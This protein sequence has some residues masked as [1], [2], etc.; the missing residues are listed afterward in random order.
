MGCWARPY[1]RPTYTKEKKKWLIRSIFSPRT[2]LSSG[3]H[4]QSECRG[5]IQCIDVN[6]VTLLQ[7][8]FLLK[9]L[10]IKMVPYGPSIK[11][12][13][14][15]FRWTK[16]VADTNYNRRGLCLLARLPGCQAARRQRPR[17]DGNDFEST[18]FSTYDLLTIIFI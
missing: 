6:L 1:V 8:L 18:I 3:T 13:F 2:L 12:S 7:R 11:Y 5:T 15:L 16:W 14:F 4:R 17:L 10:Q 9:R